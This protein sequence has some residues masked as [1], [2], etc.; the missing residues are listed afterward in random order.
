MH[1]TFICSD[2]PARSG[3][4]PHLVRI[5]GG[6][7]TPGTPLNPPLDFVKYMLCILYICKQKWYNLG[8]ETMVVISIY[9]KGG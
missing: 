3:W 2:W 5:K 9:K 4:D 8:R 6:A 7:R 1:M